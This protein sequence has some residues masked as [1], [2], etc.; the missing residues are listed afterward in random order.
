M[1]H[2]REDRPHGDVHVIPARCKECGYCVRFCPEK[3][4]GFSTEASQAPARASNQVRS[5]VA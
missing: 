2:Q 4:L 3:V 5:P 1:A